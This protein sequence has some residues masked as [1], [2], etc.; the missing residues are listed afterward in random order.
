MSKYDSPKS[1]SKV[2]VMDALKESLEGQLA[3]RA[4]TQEGGGEG[5]FSRSTGSHHSRSGHDFSRAQI[6]NQEDVVRLSE[7][8]DKEFAKEFLA[9]TRL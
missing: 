7:A 3:L 8:A 5:G 4:Y 9:Q 6:F 2:L 1:K